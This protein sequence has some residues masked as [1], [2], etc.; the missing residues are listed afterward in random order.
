MTTTAALASPMSTAE[1]ARKKAEA[2]RSR[3]LAKSADR[4]DVVS[5]LTTHRHGG[6]ASSSS[7]SSSTRDDD[8]KGEDDLHRRHG[9]D[10]AAATTTDASTSAP[11]RA[12]AIAAVDGDSS[13]AFDSPVVAASASA[14]ASEEALTSSS[15]PD[16]PPADAAVGAAAASDE[17]EGGGRGA[18]RMAAMRRRRYQSKAVVVDRPAAVVAVEEEEEEEEANGGDGES[19]GGTGSA[20]SSE[21][22]LVAEAE[23]VPATA[24]S[25]VSKEEGEGE[26]KR[27]SAVGD[28]GPKNDVSA[29]TIHDERTEEEEE[30]EE[31]VEHKKYMGVA[32]VRRRLLKEQKERRLREIARH[33][34]DGGGGAASAAEIIATMGVTASM[35]RRGV[36]VV[37]VDG[38]GGGAA[39]GGGGGGGGAT[40]GRAGGGKG[41]RAAVGVGRK[42]WY[43]LGLVVPPTKLVPRLVTLLFLLFAGLDL[44]TQHHRHPPT[45]PVP[46]S[47]P[48]PPPP[49]SYS[50]IGGVGNSILSGGGAGSTNGAFGGG[51]L[52]RHVEPSLT[53]P[54][55]Y[56]VGGKVAYM[57]GMM[58][59]SPPTALPTSFTDPLAMEECVVASG[60]G[61]YG[62]ATTAG[63]CV[64]P[65]PPSEGSDDV[66][67]GSKKYPPHS[68]D[69]DFEPRRTHRP[70]GVD[71]E[72]DDDDDDYDDHRG[73]APPRVVDPL[74]RVDLDALLRDAHLPVPIDYAAKFAIKFHR[75]WVHYLWTLPA[76]LVGY[77]LGLPRRALGGWIANPPWMLGVALLVRFVT[78]VLV[79]DGKSSS[80]LGSGKD[81]PDGGGSG[82]GGGG[83]GLG[84]NMDVLGKVAD[85]AKNYAASTFPRTSLVLGTLM[86]V[87]KVDMYVLLCGML[88]GLAIIP[89]ED[90]HPT[91]SG[92]GIID[93]VGR[94]V[95]GDGEL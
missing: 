51:G 14:S 32:R 90:G 80:S 43:G 61:K 47:P 35:V 37:D 22:A 67:M 93:A 5:G 36:A 19:G 91:W 11:P 56:G 12:T 60:G 88:I 23:E 65:P 31:E 63:I 17:G 94:P 46:Q 78:R 58:P 15:S 41:A 16:D 9:D 74:F 70:K 84:N 21:P 6:A 66:S 27:P 39:A 68:M 25:P 48:P 49:P 72:F 53:R 83:G 95:L 4:L 59:S 24:T 33:G 55:E 29:P 92:G 87:M 76:S 81:I 1:R 26:R 28:D 13:A 79:G 86:K 50:P 34:H 69:D 3:I 54:W 2:R 89:I 77:L 62:A 18:R 71:R 20:G 75:T 45:P 10:D 42:G 82:S 7:S 38:V 8:A 30:E 57:A 52:I 44:G 64:P 40:A 85:A 73:T